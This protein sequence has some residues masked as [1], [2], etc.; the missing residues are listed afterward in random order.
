[1][2]A[3]HPNCFAE[4]DHSNFEEI[5]SA[6]ETTAVV[7]EMVGCF[8]ENTNKDRWNE[9][10]LALSDLAYQHSRRLWAV[11]GHISELNEKAYEYDLLNKDVSNP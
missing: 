6:T 5:L 2:T 3:Y 9:N 1:M 7:L 11:Q 4:S 8:F 10:A